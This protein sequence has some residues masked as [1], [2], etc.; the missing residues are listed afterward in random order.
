M[1]GWLVVVCVGVVFG[2]CVGV[3]VWAYCGGLLAQFGGVVCV[4]VVYCF[5]SFGGCYVLPL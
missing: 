4:C 3:M 2:V 5:L 1:G